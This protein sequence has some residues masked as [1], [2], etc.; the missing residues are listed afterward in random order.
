MAPG[1]DTL[2]P[3]SRF[4]PGQSTHAGLHAEF[5]RP[6]PTEVLTFNPCHF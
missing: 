2:D 3:V 6:L 5:A 1:K 4:G